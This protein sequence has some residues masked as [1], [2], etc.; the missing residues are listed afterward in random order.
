MLMHKKPNKPLVVYLD[1][2]KW[3]DLGLAYYQKSRGVRFGKT[4]QRMR[5]AVKQKTARFPFSRVHILETM[6]MGDIERRKRLAQVIAEF[7]EGWTIAP[8]EKITPVEFN[9][10]AATVFNRPFVISSPVVF[11]RGIEFSLGTPVYAP[12]FIETLNS[13]NEM[14]RK[15]GIQMLALFLSS[16][17]ED[18]RKPGIDKYNASMNAIANEADQIRNLVKGENKDMR[19]RAFTAR[20]ILEHLNSKPDELIAMFTSLGVGPDDLFNL[21]ADKLVGLYENTPTMDVMMNLRIQRNHQFEKAIEP[22]DLNDFSFLSVV[23][24]YCDI[25]VTEK[26][27]VE[28]AKRKGFDQKYQTVLL[29]DLEELQNHLSATI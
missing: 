20:Q 7:S 25:V 27:W 1:Q 9:M 4:L 22:N 16:P 24:P 19:Y 23:I 11:G 18:L 14:R 3:I 6:K 21:G 13:S 8:P 17:I 28:L 10:A 26:Q 2:N 12:V 29:S 5:D 15:K